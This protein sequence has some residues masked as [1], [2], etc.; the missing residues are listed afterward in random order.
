MSVIKYIRLSE[1]LE[2]YIRDKGISGR[3]PGLYKLARELNVNPITL[4]KAIHHLAQQ[5]KLE[6]LP[7]KGTFVTAESAASREYHAIGVLG[8]CYSTESAKQLFLE[9]NQELASTGYKLMRIETSVDLL[10]K[11]PRLMLNFPVDG[12]VF[13]GS[14]ITRGILAVLQEHSIPAICT[15][16]ENFPELNQI[17]M[18]HI[19][20]YRRAVRLLMEK[21]HRK[22]AFIS[23][24]RTPSFLN[25][26]GDIRKVFASTL[27]KAF[28]PGYFLVMDSEEFFRK[29]GDDYVLKM[30]EHAMA[31][32]KDNLP[33]A[34]ISFEQ[35]LCRITERYPH[36]TT[37]SFNS[38]EPISGVDYYFCEDIKGILELAIERM[39]QLLRGDRTITRQFVKFINRK[40]SIYLQDKDKQEKAK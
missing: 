23:T 2:K 29:Y 34:I 35:I 33:D 17:G 32:W 8:Y 3:L 18:D 25:Y 15:V 12:F 36:I 20:G 7:W 39:F 6:I 22:I 30:A 5:G 11:N 19:D 27:G 13:L 38:M 9:L 24:D 31:L 4:H 21:G 14:S 26:I 16:N 40:Y 10:Q 37:V 28:D 1:R